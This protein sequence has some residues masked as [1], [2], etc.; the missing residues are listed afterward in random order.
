MMKMAERGYWQ[1]V[2]E[3]EKFTKR[4]SE[5]EKTVEMLSKEED[6]L[7]G[8]LKKVK[9]Q[10]LYYEKLTRDMKKELQPATVGS[11]LSSI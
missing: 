5:L 7:L 1:A 11:M 3:K 10:I 2:E 9:Q 6:H 4:L 8:E